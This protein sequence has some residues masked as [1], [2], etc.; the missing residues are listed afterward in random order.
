MTESRRK[1]YDENN[2]FLSEKQ[3]FLTPVSGVSYN[4]LTCMLTTSQ[5]RSHYVIDVGKEN[6]KNLSDLICHTAN[7]P[8]FDSSSKSESFA[9][10]F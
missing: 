4:I 7:K 9:L 2:K 1:I 6:Q 3:L 5:S 8:E 10:E